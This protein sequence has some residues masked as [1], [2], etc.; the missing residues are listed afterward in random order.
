[1]CS[2]TISGGGM[3]VVVLTPVGLVAS[4]GHHFFIRTG[5]GD[6]R[7]I[8]ASAE[9]EMGESLILGGYISSVP[10]QNPGA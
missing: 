9:R 5:F 1:M 3:W 7:G 6:V 2:D 8:G 10:Q 4:P